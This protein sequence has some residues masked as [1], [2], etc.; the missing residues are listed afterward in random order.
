MRRTLITN[1]QWGLFLVLNAIT[2]T[3]VPH[4]RD[5]PWWGLILFGTS[6]Y[7]AFLAIFRLNWE[8][9]WQAYERR[10]DARHRRW[11]RKY[12]RDEARKAQAD[13]DA[14]L[15]EWGSR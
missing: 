7:T 1:L 13:R 11:L 10:K 4:L 2:W 12:Q 6:Y 8:S 3:I 14:R 15:R 9:S 5:F